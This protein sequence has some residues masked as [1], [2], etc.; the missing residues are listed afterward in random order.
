[1][2]VSCVR[3]HRTV[4]TKDWDSQED[5]LWKFLGKPAAAKSLKVL[6]CERLHEPLDLFLD[7]R[8]KTVYACEHAFYSCVDLANLAFPGGRAMCDILREWCVPESMPQA[9]LPCLCLP[10]P[11]PMLIAAHQWHAIM[12]V[13][14]KY[15]SSFNPLKFDCNANVHS[16]RHQNI[17]I[18]QPEELGSMIDREHRVCRIIRRLTEWT[19]CIVEAARARGGRTLPR[20]CGRP[21][22]MI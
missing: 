3:M 1:M 12:I 6:H 14:N 16:L 18:W 4:I 11:L 13:G 20:Q 10:E 17:T 2:F 19:P 5:Y 15:L 22:R 8:G 7:S 21:S 9:K